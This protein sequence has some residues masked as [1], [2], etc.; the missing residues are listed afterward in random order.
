MSD[1]SRSAGSTGKAALAARLA[2]PLAAALAALL[3]PAP[4]AAVAPEELFV[5]HA[6]TGDAGV[7]VFATDV[8]GNAAPIRAIAGPA[9]GITFPEGAAVDRCNDEIV[10]TNQDTARGLANL[11]IFRRSDHGDVAPQRVIQ[12]GLTELADPKGVALVPDHDEIVVANLHTGITVHDRRVPGNVAP[13]RKIAGPATGI[14]QPWGVAYDFVTDEIIVASSGNA[15]IRVFDR[16]ARDDAPPKRVIQ[17][18]ASGLV[19]IRGVAMEPSRAVIAVADLAGSVKIFVAPLLGVRDQ[20]PLQTL[21]GLSKPI[22]VAF[23][24]SST[25][26]FVTEAAPHNRV[27]VFAR[28]GP[29][30]DTYT[31]VRTIEGPSTG[32]NGPSLPAVMFTPSLPTTQLVAAVLPLSRS[33]QVGGITATAF[34]TVINTGISTACLVGIS[35]GLT[36][37]AEFF[38]NHTHPSTNQPTGT[39]K[40]IRPGFAQPFVIGFTPTAPFGPLDMPFVFAGSNTDPVPVLVGINT[41]LLSASLTPVPDVVAVAATQG[42]DGIVRIPGP[43]GTGTFAVA[44]TNLGAADTITVTADTGATPVPV[45]TLVCHTDATGACDA[46]PAPSVTLFVGA[47]ATPTFGFFATASTAIPLDPAAHRIFVRYRD[48][49]GVVRGATGVAVTTDP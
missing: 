23:G 35:P 5:P 24:P 29:Q 30:F 45:V 22:G 3:A 37:P 20:A 48:S 39:F 42:N 13:I 10:L 18:P 47:G 43:P 31:R 40:S 38:F 8:G 21:A 15:S 1:T 28:T 11:L 34:A 6:N 33:V 36:V 14:V 16:T 49:T 2:L 4:A 12:G 32:L 17:G 9:G 27:V 25:E 26:L 46:P 44:T 19:Q 41:L 7:R